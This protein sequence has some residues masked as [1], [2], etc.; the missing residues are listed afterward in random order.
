MKTEYIGVIN[1]IKTWLVK[2]ES[3]EV[4]GKNETPEHFEEESKEVTDGY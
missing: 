2:N 1:G 3:G 4:V